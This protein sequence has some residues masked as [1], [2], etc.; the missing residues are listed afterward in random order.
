MMCVGLKWPVQLLMYNIIF[1]RTFLMR[2]EHPKVWK[3]HV[4]Q[5]S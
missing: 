2:E 3:R 4:Y 1:Q 5:L